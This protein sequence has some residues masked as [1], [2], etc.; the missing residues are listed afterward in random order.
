[1][2]SRNADKVGVTFSEKFYIVEF[3][4]INK[5]KIGLLGC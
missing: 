5:T 4:P 3:F 1:M 2:V